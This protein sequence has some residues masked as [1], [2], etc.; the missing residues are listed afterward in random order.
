MSS[1]SMQ[2]NGRVAPAKRLIYVLDEVAFTIK[3]KMV[4]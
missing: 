4:Q 2:L 3:P 1:G